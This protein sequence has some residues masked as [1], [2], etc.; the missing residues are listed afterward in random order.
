M[1]LP[2]CILSDPAC[3]NCERFIP[4]LLTFLDPL[5]FFSAECWCCRVGGPVSSRPPLSSLSLTKAS[6]AF[7]LHK[8]THWNDHQ[9]ACKRLLLHS[10]IHRDC[11]VHCQYVLTKQKSWL[12]ALPCY[13]I[14]EY[15][16]YLQSLFQNALNAAS[17]LK[18]H[19]VFSLQR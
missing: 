14:D 6:N 16:M 7:G 9:A 10:G 2:F 4:S 11:W 1:P 12:S 17:L 5:C 3:P 13:V 8:Q 18:G 15:W 19:T